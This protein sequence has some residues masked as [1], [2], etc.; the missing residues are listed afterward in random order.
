MSRSHG[1]VHRLR[2]D[3]RLESGTDS[4]RRFARF[5][6][7][8]AGGFIV[9]VG[10]LAVLTSLLGVH[11]LAATVIAVE[12]AILANFACHYRWTWRDRSPSGPSG[13]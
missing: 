3:S 13:Q 9:Q 11:Y 2:T 1:G 6:V 8:G 12:A 7:A 10:T 5:V 4:L